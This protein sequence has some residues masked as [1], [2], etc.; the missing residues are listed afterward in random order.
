[1]AKLPDM[2]SV[3]YKSFDAYTA[4]NAMLVVFSSKLSKNDR[5]IMETKRMVVGQESRVVSTE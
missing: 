1:M 2:K 3:P 4:R 5:D